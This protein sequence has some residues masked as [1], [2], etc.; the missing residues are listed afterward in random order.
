[1]GNEQEAAL[2]AKTAELKTAITAAGERVIAKLDELKA[3]NPD[4]TDE[5]ADITSDIEALNAIAA[6]EPTPTP[7]PAPEG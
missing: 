4:L 2:D 1:M 6:P 7:E 5:I 3:N